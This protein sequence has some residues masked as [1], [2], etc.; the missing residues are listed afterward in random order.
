MQAK[1]TTRNELHHF[2]FSE[3]FIAEMKQMKGYFYTILD[4]VTILPEN[5]CNRDIR[6]MRANELML[7]ITEGNIVSMIEEGYI[8]Y[9]AD[10]EITNRIEDKAVEQA[11]YNALLKTF[12]GGQIYAVQKE[13]KGY[14]FS[15]DTEERTYLFVVQGQE[16]IEEWNRFLNKEV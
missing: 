1:Y 5:S 10:G 2:Q 8:V 13:D 11:E 15:I 6:E 7:T 16:D 12:S 14:T 3:A 9:N 4:N